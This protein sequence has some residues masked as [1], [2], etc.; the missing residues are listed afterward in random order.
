MAET[1]HA[2]RWNYLEEKNSYSHHDDYYFY[3]KLAIVNT[4]TVLENYQKVEKENGSSILGEIFWII[5]I[6]GVGSFT[7][8]TGILIR[9]FIKKRRNFDESTI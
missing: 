4:Q 6:I 5:P 3:R 9:N 2:H 7:V 8:L 1:L